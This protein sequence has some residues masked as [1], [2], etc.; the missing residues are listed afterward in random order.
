MRIG[1][2]VLAT[3]VLAGCASILQGSPAP[4]PQSFPGIAGELTTRGIVIGKYQSGDDGCHDS[5]LTPT[6]IGFDASGLGVTTPIHLRIYIFGSG[7]SY[8][9]RRPDVDTCVT[10][11]ATDPSTV[12]FVEAR[13]FVLAGQGPWPDAFKAAIREALTAAAGV[14]D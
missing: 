6:A 2:V 9:R 12:E 8:D 5:T 11:W 4:T 1:F 7:A 10:A 14:G 3:V 13:P